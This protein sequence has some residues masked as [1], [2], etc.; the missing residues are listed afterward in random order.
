[1]E[2]RERHG[3][4]GRVR[5][6]ARREDGTTEVWEG[7]NLITDAGRDALAGALRGEPVEIT[8]VALGA[9]NTPPASG[10]RSL[11]Q[12]RFRKAVTAQSA[13]AGNGETITTVYIGPGEANDFTIQEIGWFTADG[14]MIARVLYSRDKTSLESLQIDRTDTIN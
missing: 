13:G 2:L 3:W 10:D 9:D 11:G 5:V 8:A 1:M 12:E 14:R 4:R 7:D 6:T